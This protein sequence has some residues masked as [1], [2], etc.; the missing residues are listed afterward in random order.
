MNITLTDYEKSVL[1][2]WK[3]KHREVYLMKKYIHWYKTEVNISQRDF[4][5]RMNQF[6]IGNGYKPQKSYTSVFHL[7]HESVT[8]LE[9]K[10]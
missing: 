8:S 1:E 4:H 2:N 10:S 3:R 7:W 5:Q 9:M 6:L